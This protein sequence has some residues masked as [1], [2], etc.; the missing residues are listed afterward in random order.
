MHTGEEFSDDQKLVSLDILGLL[1]LDFWKKLKANLAARVHDRFLQFMVVFCELPDSI[2]CVDSRY[3][4]LSARD[5]KDET[6]DI[7]SLSSLICAVW[8]WIEERRE[9][10]GTGGL[11]CGR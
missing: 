4:F 11:G 9:G 10:P 6:S 8:S 5:A 1:N 2:H 7:S 3:G